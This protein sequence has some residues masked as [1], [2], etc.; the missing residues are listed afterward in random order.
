M[1]TASISDIDKHVGARIRL[2]RNSV[3][4]SQTD[5]ATQLGL[6]FQQVQKYE[7]GTN[8]VGSGRLAEIA[9]ILG[10]DITYFFDQAPAARAN[11]PTS[12]KLTSARKRDVVMQSWHGQAVI[13]AMSAMRPSTRDAFVKIARILAGDKS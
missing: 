10:T 9:T 5:L 11:G 7:K 13:A 6:T 2:R 4:M 8:R 1:A 3:S 12:E